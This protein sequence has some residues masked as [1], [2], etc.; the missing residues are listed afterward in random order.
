VTDR[1]GDPYDGRLT[2]HLDLQM[3][4]PELVALDEIIGVDDFVRCGGEDTSHTR[5]LLALSSEWPPIYLHRQSMVV[6]DGM[7]RVC[8]ARRRGDSEILV[9]FL[10]GPLAD[11]FILG[12]RA[13]T[14]YGKPLTLAER[15]RSATRILETHS[16]W[17]DGAIAEACGVSSKT[18]AALRRSTQENPELN[19]RRIGRDGKSR[20]VDPTENR[21]RAAQLLQESPQAS[22]REIARQ[23]EL[24]PATVKSVRD[25]LQRDAAHPSAP[26][27][28]APIGDESGARPAIAED[29]A[30]QSTERGAAFATWFE[31][32]LVTTQDW[33]EFVGVI[34]V[35]RIYVIADQARACAEAW[36]SFAE[37]LEARVTRRRV[38]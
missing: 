38:G 20:P 11:A 4:E 16:H 31:S 24:S 36:R 21:R 5:A 35:S 26:S 10:S 37:A 1:P 27:A 3:G 14:G 29:A 17:S 34:P 23:A 13:N 33:Q 28:G 22:L 25:R 9:C 7:H 2:E 18:V 15:E 6:V 8:A 32:R 12:V 19:R 30:V